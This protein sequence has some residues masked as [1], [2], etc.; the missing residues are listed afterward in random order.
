MAPTEGVTPSLFEFVPP[1]VPHG[2]NTR[3]RF[4]AFHAAN[5]WVYGALVGLA[6]EWRR[7]GHRKLAIATLF[8]VLR[9]Q[10]H[11]RTVDTSSSFK[12]NN[13]MKPHY[14]RE[15]MAHERDLADVFDLRELKS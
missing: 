14:A 6:R 11:R 10:W 8:E 1:V 2:A 3:E 13:N 4:E 15:I 7:H 5:P 12:L 9:W